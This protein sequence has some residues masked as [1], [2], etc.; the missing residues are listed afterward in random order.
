MTAAPAASRL[1]RRVAPAGGFSLLEMLVAI[2]IAGVSIALIYRSL[3]DGA[4]KAAELLQR[5]RAHLLLE[6]LLQTPPDRL[7][8]P[9]PQEGRSGNLIWRIEP[10]ADLPPLVLQS[11]GPEGGTDRI[12]VARSPSARPQALRYSV[13]WAGGRRQINVIAWRLASPA[14]Q[15]GR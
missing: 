10:V 4:S 11:A 14:E 8:Y 3:G 7:P 15:G 5:Q 6:G 9:L 1:R 12:P 13:W 2:A